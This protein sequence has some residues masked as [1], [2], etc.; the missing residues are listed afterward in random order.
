VPR[1]KADPVRHRH[2]TTLL[3]T[4]RHASLPL[5]DTENVRRLLVIEIRLAALV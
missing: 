3:G 4:A 2:W 1:L 5:I